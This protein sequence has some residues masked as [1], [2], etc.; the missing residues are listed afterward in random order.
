MVDNLLCLDLLLIVLL[1][2]GGLRYNKRARNRSATCLTPRRPAAPLHPHSQEPQPLPGLTHQ[3]HCALCEQVPASVSAA[4]RVPPAPLPASPGRPRQVD[5]PKP[6]CP[7]PCCAYYG[8]KGL[9]NIRANGY[10]NGGRWRQ[11]PCLGV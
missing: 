8:W 4:P 6:F 7:Q 1:W 3:P 9:G 5:T 10:P 11:L 2:L